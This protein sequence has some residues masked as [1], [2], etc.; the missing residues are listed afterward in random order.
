MQGMFIASD[1]NQL[2]AGNGASFGV[3]VVDFVNYN[4]ENVSHMAIRN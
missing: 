2:M 1:H 3:L 4:S